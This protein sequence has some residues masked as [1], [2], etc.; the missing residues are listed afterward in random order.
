MNSR[1]LFITNGHG[2]IAI[3]DRIAQEV[4][5]LSMAQLR[6]IILR[7]SAIVARPFYARS[8]PAPGDAQR[9]T[10]GDGQS[11]QHRARLVGSGLL[12]LTYRGSGAS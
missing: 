10:A 11:A 4:C 2:E 8:R 7:W 6:S 3:A 1:L 9:G 5:A 12:T